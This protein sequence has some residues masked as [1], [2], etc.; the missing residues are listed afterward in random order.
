MATILYTNAAALEL[1]DVVRT[2]LAAS[3]VR[4]FKENL[5][6]SILTTL[7]EL[8]AAVCDFSN[9]ADITLTN[10]LAVYFDPAGGAT[11]PSGSLQWNWAP[12]GSGD[13]V[14]N[15]VYGF[16]VQDADDNVRAVG[17]FDNA[18]PME[19]VGNAVPL[20]IGLNYGKNA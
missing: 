19:E 12:P 10:W 4:L 11:V 2:S 14:S 1:A 9:Y 16:W 5:N 18:I 3:K 6:V 7:A 20:T 17:K 8:E 15:D 13:P